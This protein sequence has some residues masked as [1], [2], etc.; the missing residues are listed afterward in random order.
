ML[1]D[2]TAVHAW[3]A[4]W[5]AALNRPGDPAAVARAVHPDAVVERF[6]FG[7][8]RGRCVQ[9]LRGVDAIAAWAALTNPVCRFAPDGAAATSADPPVWV[10]RYVITADDFRGGGVWRFRL[11]Q[12]ARLEWLRHEPDDLPS[13]WSR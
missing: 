6:G 5:L 13:E 9:T 4:A 8:Q 12:D 2:A 3:L 1:H 10:V 7:P 11:T